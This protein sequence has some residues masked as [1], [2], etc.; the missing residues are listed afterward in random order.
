MRSLKEVIEID[1]GLDLTGWDLTV[2]TVADTST[3]P[4]NEEK[5]EEKPLHTFFPRDREIIRFPASSLAAVA[6]STPEPQPIR[7]ESRR[8]LRAPSSWWIDVN[9]S[10]GE[11]G[12]FGQHGQGGE[13]DKLRLVALDLAAGRA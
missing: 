12:R 2:G 8:Q 3:D 13:S 10:N 5:Q 9:R 7:S 1:F 11:L 4:Q 6:R